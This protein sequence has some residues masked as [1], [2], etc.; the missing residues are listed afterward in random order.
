MDLPTRVRRRRLRPRRTIRP[1]LRR[2]RR[3]RHGHAQRQRRSAAP[4]TSTARYRFDVSG[5][6]RTIGQRA[7]RRLRS[8]G[9][10]AAAVRDRIGDLPNPY[11]TPFNFVRKM[12]CNFGWDWGPQLTTSGLWRPVALERWRRCTD[13]RRP[14]DAALDTDDATSRRDRA[15][16]RGRRPRRRPA[17]RRAP[18]CRSSSRHRDGDAVG[19]GAARPL[20]AGTASS[21]VN[22]DVPDVRALV[23]GGV[24]RPAAVPVGGRGR[25]RRGVLRPRR[26]RRSA[27]GRWA[28][29]RA[30]DPTVGRS[31]S[32]STA[33][34]SGSAASTGSP[35]TAFRRATRASSSPVCSPRPPRRTPTSCASGAA[36][37]TRATSS[38][39]SATDVDCW[40]GR[41]FRSPVPPTPRTLLH[42]EVAA[43]AAD[44]IT[45][46][47]PHPSLV[48]WCGN[49]ECL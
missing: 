48:L 40:C 41:T 38:T 43:E 42:D 30:S 8:P 14:S 26:R 46:L 2:H 24:R 1:R 4:R 5:A 7:R 27:F 35:P 44:N 6:A 9:D 34:G 25:R 23:A 37:C 31:P 29:T 33:S 3:V 32:T 45:R 12:A 18:P 28:S 39:T 15:H 11:G 36:A 16:R 17:Q 20:D 10:H 13:P 19:R 21:T 22:V 47:M 49:N